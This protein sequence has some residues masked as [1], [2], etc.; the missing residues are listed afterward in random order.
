MVNKSKD[1]K[2]KFSSPASENTQPTEKNQHISKQP[3]WKRWLIGCGFGLLS[4]IIGLLLLF[5]AGNII[6]AKTIYPRV[7]VGS[8][9]VGTLSPGATKEQL[10][11][12]LD[13]YETRKLVLTLSNGTSYTVTPKELGFNP[14][15]ETTIT[16]AYAV[17]RDKN[18]LNSLYQMG[19]LLLQPK[20]IS[21]ISTDNSAK[22][23]QYIS[24]LAQ[25]VDKPERDATL[26]L[27]DGKL[28]EINSAEGS[29][30]DQANASVLIKNSL[31][32]LSDSPVKLAIVTTLPKVYQEGLAKATTQAKQILTADI[33]LNFQQKSYEIKNDQLSQWLIFRAG[34]VPVE[35]GKGYYLEATLN[36]EKMHAYIT[37]IAHQI[38]Q[39]PV[40]AKL[41]IVDGKATVFA[42]SSNGYKVDQDALASSVSQA[43][44]Q[45]GQQ[46]LTIPV[47]TT[48]PQI[49]SDKI[50]SL[51]INELIGS[52][53]TSFVHSPDNRVHNI[54]TGAQ[55]LNGQLVKPGDTFSTLVALG[56]IDG[57]TGY[58]PEL[59]IK[60]D[61]TVPEFGG[62]LCQVSTTLFRAALSA[63]V[64]IV[65]RQNHSWRISYYEPPVGLDATIYLPAPDFKFKNDTPGWILIQ[66]NVDVDNSKITFQ[67][68]GSK[69][70]RT[71]KIIGPTLLYST[72]APDTVY[73]DDP[74]LATGETK[75]LQAPH[76]GGKATATYQVFD[77]DGKKINE[78]TFVSIYKAS[79]AQYLRGTGPA[80]DQPTDQPAQ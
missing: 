52:A 46:T 70:G 47:T 71:S 69:D 26:I 25:K 30:L 56:K 38:D 35:N 68:Y 61:K 36:E 65:E 48:Q 4:L 74:T 22:I 66:S 33:N 12:A 21:L 62:G 63:G 13:N 43:I 76:P 1:K 5:G 20:V 67:L 29:R 58:L 17:G 59:V 77:K 64:P 73:V 3:W 24:S 16:A 8:L 34:L 55:F 9:A 19:S 53:T 57:S 44:L 72:P 37:T 39:D 49:S 45:G 23:T 42:P 31:S 60:E 14:N 79:A 75:R 50:N 80:A 2:Q 54:Q 7:Y 11:R 15:I 51:G 78:Q 10:T 6:F 27:N 32:S 18:A 41:T 28:K 40:D